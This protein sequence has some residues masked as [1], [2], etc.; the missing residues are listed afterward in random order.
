MKPASTLKA[1]SH[2]ESM[3]QRHEHRLQVAPAPGKKR[4]RLLVAVGLES[5]SSATQKA[6]L[7]VWNDEATRLLLR[8]VGRDIPPCRLSRIRLSATD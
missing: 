1:L 3:M 4:I 6:A 8:L 5:P 2:A 7:E